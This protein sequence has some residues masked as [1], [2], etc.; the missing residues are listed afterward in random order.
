LRTFCDQASTQQISPIQ[1]RKAIP[2]EIGIKAVTAAVQSRKPTYEP[3]WMLV[4]HTAIMSEKFLEISAAKRQ[5][6]SLDL[7]QRNVV[8]EMFFAGNQGGKPHEKQSRPSSLITLVKH[9]A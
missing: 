9:G 7:C 8:P 6:S 3:F 1:I 4:F 2:R 5:L